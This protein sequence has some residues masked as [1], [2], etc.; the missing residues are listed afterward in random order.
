LD[1]AKASASVGA[2]GTALKYN[3]TKAM[4]GSMLNLP[5]TSQLTTAPPRNSTC[6]K[7]AAH[8]EHEVKQQKSAMR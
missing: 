8:C 7:P 5:A 4:E 6:H 1:L 2:S 3:S